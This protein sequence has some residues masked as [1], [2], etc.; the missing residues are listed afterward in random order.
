MCKMT[1]RFASING[2]ATASREGRR[3]AKE[4]AGALR[5]NGSRETARGSSPSAAVL[6]IPSLPSALYAR[7]LASVVS[8]GRQRLVLRRRCDIVS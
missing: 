5:Y 7:P 2:A 8:D 6:A 1:G 3:R 4:G